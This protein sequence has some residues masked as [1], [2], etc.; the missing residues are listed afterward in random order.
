M[1]L[2]DGTAPSGPCTYRLSIQLINGSLIHTQPVVPR[3]IRDRNGPDVFDPP[4]VDEGGVKFTFRSTATAGHARARVFNARGQWV[5]TVV[6]ADFP[7]GS[8]TVV[9]DRRD[10][11]G[12]S[13]RR[14]VY[15]TT[16]E[17]D[18]ITAT[19]KLVLAD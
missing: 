14:G 5:R 9:W 16:Y 4:Q 6:D 7:A 11:A 13:V 1:Q 10:A 8:H 3:G 12:N 2:V 19:Y 15:F 17:V 18:G